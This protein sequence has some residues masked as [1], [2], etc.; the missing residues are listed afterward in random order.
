[1]QKGVET[2]KEENFRVRGGWMCVELDWLISFS[3][4]FGFL[5]STLSS[6]LRLCGMEREEF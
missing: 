5:S 4:T 3:Q 2:R 6:S 1:M